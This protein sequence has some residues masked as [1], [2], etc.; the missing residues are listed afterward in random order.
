MSNLELADLIDKR[1]IVC[2]LSTSLTYCMR[3]AFWRKESVVFLYRRRLL[4]KKKE[5]R[6]VKIIITMVVLP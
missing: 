1:H 4:G 5:R 6:V 3:F 2:L